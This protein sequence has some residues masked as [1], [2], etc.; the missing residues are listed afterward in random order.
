[1]RAQVLSPTKQGAAGSLDL[2]QRLQPL[3]NPRA[4]GKGEVPAPS[5]HHHHH[6]N[7]GRAA[8]V[9]RVGDRVIHLVND[10]ERDVMNGD[11]GYVV[12]VDGRRREVVVHFPPRGGGSDAHSVSYSLHDAAD[13]LQLAWATTVHKVRATAHSCVRA[14]VAGVLCLRQ[15]DSSAD[16]VLLLAAAAA[17]VQAQ[18]V[19]FPV[20][21]LPL[22]GSAGAF[23][24]RRPLLYTGVSR[25]KRLL[26]LV[27]TQ[28]A[29]QLCVRN[30]GVDAGWRGG[31]QQPH[32]SPVLQLVDRLRAAA[33]AKGL[34]PFPRL[35]FGQDGWREEVGGAWWAG[36]ARAALCG[37]HAG[38]CAD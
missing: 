29:L 10:V 22:H 21:V 31:R 25:A 4:E 37:A 35:V 14:C 11:L 27:G 34:Q 30:A 36:V 28:A 8:P 20:V 15:E 2:A 16:R 24:L 26:V 32:Q 7:S 13:E 17:L 3:L 1:M 18:G 9:W 6:S 19:E 5:H 23:L 38:R 12:G 33:A